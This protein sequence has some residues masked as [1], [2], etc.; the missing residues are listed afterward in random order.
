[1]STGLQRHVHSGPARIAALAPAIFQSRP[2]GVQATQL[3]VKPLAN[4]LA[5]T[6]NNSSDKGI[7]TDSSPS[8]LRKLKGPQEMPSIHGCELRSHTTD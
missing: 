3:S 7:G 4:H 2:L 6:H 8:T 5:I 1:M